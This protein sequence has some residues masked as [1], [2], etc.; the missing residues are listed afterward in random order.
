MSLDALENLCVKEFPLSATRP[1]IMAG[2]REVLAR[3]ART[4]LG[5]HIWINGSFVTESIDPADVDMVVMTSSVFY[6]DGTPAQKALIA[7]LES[8]DNE[9]KKHFHCDAF[10]ELLPPDGS[11]FEYLGA[12]TKR[13]WEKI[14]GHGPN[15][16]DPKGIA[17]LELKSLSI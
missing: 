8:K 2:L 16:G 17:V 14:F 6:D 7:W 9:P 1:K 5:G 15:T 11:A 13:H 12:D 3:I 10:I 4:K